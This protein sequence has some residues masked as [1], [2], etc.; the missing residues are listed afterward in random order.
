MKT[1]EEV[2]EGWLDTAF[3]PEIDGNGLKNNVGFWHAFAVNR[4]AQNYSKDIDRGVN[5]WLS[6]CMARGAKNQQSVIPFAKNLIDRSMFHAWIA[7]YKWLEKNGDIR[8]IMHRHSVSSEYRKESC[9]EVWLKRFIPSSE[10]SL[11]EMVS[12]ILKNSNRLIELEDIKVLNATRRLYG[13]SLA[14]MANMLIDFGEFSSIDLTAGRRAWELIRDAS[15]E[16]LAKDA[17]EKLK[18]LRKIK[19]KSDKYEAKLIT[20]SKICEAITNIKGHNSFALEIIKDLIKIIAN[21]DLLIEA[22][23]KYGHAPS[24][25]TEIPLN[26]FS[27]QLTREVLDCWFDG[28]KM[29]NKNKE[30]DIEV[31]MLTK[32]KFEEN[33]ALKEWAERKLLGI[34]LEIDTGISKVAVKRTI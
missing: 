21:D 8:D 7:A 16:N 34:T 9:L 2:F 28:V 30:K 1:N 4:I 15:T 10:L 20:Y 6:A 19:N 25:Y 18:G 32:N 31:L 33:A 3:G 5:D 11:D 23:N 13:H 27:R 12:V 29:L 14:R 26:M 22:S 24:E 17:T